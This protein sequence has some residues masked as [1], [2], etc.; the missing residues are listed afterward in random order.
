MMAMAYDKLYR[1]DDAIREFEAARAVD[2]TYPG[3]HMGW[4]LS[5]G[6]TRRNASF[7]EN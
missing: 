2:P 1:E 4:A 5:T 7:A 6:E 3:I